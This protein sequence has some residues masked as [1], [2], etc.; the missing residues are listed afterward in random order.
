MTVLK[1]D[2]FIRA[3]LKQSVDRTPVW[4]MRQAGRY[5]PEYRKVRE[6]AGSFLNLCTN[7]ELACEV[8]LQPL[9]RFDFDAAIL[10]SDILTIPDAMGLGL[11][12]TEGEGPKFTSP[13]RTAADVNKLPIPDPETDLRYVVD[14]VRLIRK[15]LQGSVPLI[16]F[17]GSPWTLATY[18]VEGGSSKSFQKV[19]GMM[20]EQP[21]LMHVM[22]D[23]LAQSVA[24]YLNAQ[25]EAGAQAVMLFDT[26]GGMLTSEDYVEFSLYYAKQVRALLKTDVD[27]QQI[28]TILFTKGGG[29]WLESMADSGYDA[30]G[31]DWQTDIGLARA[32]VGDK[33]ALQGNMDPVSLYASP[34]VI[35]EK[36]KAIL[37]KYGSGS[38]H[39]FNL[40]H[41]ILPDI[42]PEHVKAMVDAIREYSPVYHQ[43]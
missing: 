17:S 14:A 26:W 37:R 28:P 16:G 32:R 4:M 9:R 39:V 19:K 10:F 11:Y 13:V 33:V 12:F 30:L 35:T 24:A 31:L 5:L 2:T 1:N 7:P 23:K 8:T 29:L 15:A 43:S 41:G 20:Y 21:R 3:L 38:G 40:G 36:V 18:M 27:G 6:Q 25:I 22:L 34:E 42:N